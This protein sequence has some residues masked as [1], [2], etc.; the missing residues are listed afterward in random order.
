MKNLNLKNIIK[1]NFFKDIKTEE[2]FSFEND[3]MEKYF[4]EMNFISYLSDTMFID[5][6]IPEDYEKIRN[7]I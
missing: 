6:G 3:I 5:I 1:K 2:V 7:I 4:D